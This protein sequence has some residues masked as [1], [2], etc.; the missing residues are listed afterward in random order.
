MRGNRFGEIV[1]TGLV[2]AALGLMAPAAQAGMDE[3][4][5]N[6][7]D[8]RDGIDACTRVIESKRYARRDLAWAYH[9]R[10]LAYYNIDRYEDSLL[11][12]IQVL[13][14]DPNFR[15][16]YLDRANAKCMLRQG[17]TAIDDYQRAID[18]DAIDKKV[19]WQQFLRDRGY[20]RGAIDGDFGPRSRRAMLA[21]AEDNCS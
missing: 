15:R 9:N 8:P 14:I 16:A 4:C 17:Q 20:Y 11:D 1:A 19:E 3:D 2:S 5:V 21:W 13:S 12:L 7:R 10:A 18:Y 6:A